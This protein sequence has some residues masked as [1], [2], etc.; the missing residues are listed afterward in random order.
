MLNHILSSEWKNKN[1]VSQE[2]KGVGH[3][4]SS[5]KSIHILQKKD[6]HDSKTEFTAAHL[7][8]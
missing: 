8:K 1:K 7:G 6:F 4:C 5:T 3:K 2:Q